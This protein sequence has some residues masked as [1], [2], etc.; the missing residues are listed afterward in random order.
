M[1]IFHLL[2]LWMHFMQVNEMT[3]VRELSI[4]T[5]LSS[6]NTKFLQ[7]VKVLHPRVAGVVYPRSCDKYVIQVDSHPCW[8]TQE[9]FNNMLEDTESRRHPE[10]QHVIPEQFPVGITTF[11]AS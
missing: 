8:H 5:S 11:L 3:Q 9:P 10:N 6:K 7:N 2:L 4:S 1:N